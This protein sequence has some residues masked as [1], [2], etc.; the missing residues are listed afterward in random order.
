MPKVVIFDLDGTVVNAYKA[1]HKSLNFTLNKFDYPPVTEQMAKRT[2]G[3]GDV[4]FIQAFFK[5]ADV[6]AAL[7]TYR[8]HHKRALVKYSTI[9]PGAKRVLRILG[10]RGYKLAVASNRPK[11]FSNILLRSLGLKDYFSVVMCGKSKE[12][13][14]PKPTLLLAIMRRFKCR[15]DEVTYV[16][17]MTIDVQAGRN[18]GVRTIAV[19]GGSST[20]AELKRERPFR[21]VGSLK[22]ILK[23][24]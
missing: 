12:D 6:E 23:F 3:M 24:V 19:L 2:V 4:N 13:I 10:K 17:D 11:K 1:I 20:R 21:I 8:S 18:A 7:K 15:R 14:K 9:Q 22:E 5:E 16:G